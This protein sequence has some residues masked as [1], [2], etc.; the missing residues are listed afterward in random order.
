MGNDTIVAISTALGQ[1][2]ISIVRLSGEEAIE[3]VNKSFSGT[4][5][6]NV[7]S[8]TIHYGHIVYDDKNIDEVMISVF[9]APKSFT[10]EDIIEINCHGGV[11][12][13][14]KILEIML[15]NGA[16]SANPGEFTERAFLNGRIDL[17]QAEA[18]MEIIEAKSD[19]SLTL[20]NKGLDGVIY[21]LITDLRTDLIDIIANIE[22]NIDYPE[23]DDVLELSNNILKPKIEKLIEKIENILEK[24]HYGK[25]IKEGI[26]TAIIGRPN[27]GKSS[28]LNALLRED[29]AIVTE[30]LG[31]T[32][33]IVEGNVN[34]G[35]IILN[36]IDTAGIRESSDL[37]EKIGINKAKTAINE[38]E[39]ILFV[40]DNNQALTNEDKE[41]LELT[42]NKKRIVIINKK[43]LNKELTHSFNNS[44]AISALHKTGIEDLEN[45]IRN[46]FLSGEINLSDQTYVSNA[47]HI[48][49]LSESL[50]A[51]KESI[52]AIHNEMPVDMAEIDLK[53]AWMLLGEIIGDTSTTS[54]L[55]EL[56]SKFCLGK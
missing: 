12:V 14:N 49:K 18:V 38:A 45:M 55:D 44:V 26:K 51:L 42:K 46:M 48:A 8:H 29:K 36:L 22:V 24:A 3:I 11:F 19:M 40:L 30:I 32:R 50:I 43:D 28:I 34:I 1:G 2:A 31:T 10:T 37:V 13:A 33:D 17:T 47:R 27:V 9:K 23:Y 52:Q 20:A 35:G 7:K 25:I 39:L 56:F 5:L 21:K 6:G 41:L 4:N 15:I 53:N 16:R 54:L